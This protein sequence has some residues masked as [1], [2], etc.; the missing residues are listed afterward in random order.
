MNDCR[1]VV[2]NPDQFCNLV[3][4]IVLQTDAIEKTGGR[5]EMP[6]CWHCSVTAPPGNKVLKP[7]L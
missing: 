2:F 6:V 1:S 5:K 3:S 7:Y 4:C